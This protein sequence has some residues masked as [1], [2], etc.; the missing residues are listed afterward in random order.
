LPQDQIDKLRSEAQ[1]F[2]EQEAASY[3]SSK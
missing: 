2:L 1:K 3:N